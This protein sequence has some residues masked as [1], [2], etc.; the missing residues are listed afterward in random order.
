MS[1]NRL[2]PNA[3]WLQKVVIRQAVRED[4]IGLE[5]DGEFTHFRRVYAD[6]FHRSQ[7][8]LAQIWVADLP[9]KGI[10]GQ[11]FIQLICDRHELADG[12]KRAYLYSFRIRPQYRGSGLGTRVME[13]VED[14]LRRRGFKSITLNVAKDNLRAQQLYQRRG[15]KQVAHEPGIWSYPDDKG[16]WHNVEEPAWRMEKCLAPPCD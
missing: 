11:V 4:L 8:G 5:W 7:Q 2:S 9:D 10:I 12:C 1:A 6:A 16:V 15:Y 13:I 14:D 3:D